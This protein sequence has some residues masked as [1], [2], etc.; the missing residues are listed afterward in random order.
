MRL[1]QGERTA[2]AADVELLG[3]RQRRKVPSVA[4][5]ASVN[6]VSVV[7]RPG[8]VQTT[9]VRRRVFRRAATLARQ[10]PTHRREADAMQPALAGRSG[11]CVQILHCLIPP[12]SNSRVTEDGTRKSRCIIADSW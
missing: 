2:W 6:R 9:A 7:R 1:L 4:G 8:P 12:W 5:Q 11:I 10:A 3:W